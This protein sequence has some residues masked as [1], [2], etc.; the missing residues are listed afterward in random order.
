M[1]YQNEKLIEFEKYI[2]YKKVAI[3]GLGVSNIPLID[4]LHDKKAYGTVFDGRDSNNIPKDLLDKIKDY[5]MKMS[6]GEKYL[7]NLKGFDGFTPL[8]YASQEGH[9]DI[10][11]YL[12]EE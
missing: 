8:Q 11:K 10:V 6:F 3:I 7:S 1:E 2:K 9:L 4:Y 5:D 12:I